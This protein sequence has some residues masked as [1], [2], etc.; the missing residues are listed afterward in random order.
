MIYFQSPQSGHV[1]YTTKILAKISLY[2]K[3][4]NIQM[5]HLIYVGWN[6]KGLFESSTFIYR[7]YI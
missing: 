3:I 2:G 5:L 6:F 7:L 4:K 1:K